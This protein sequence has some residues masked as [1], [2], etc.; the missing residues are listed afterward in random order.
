MDQPH[1]AGV[2]A[3]GP[4]QALAT[5]PAHR[6]AQHRV[7]HPLPPPSSPPWGRRWAS[8]PPP[9]PPPA[10]RQQ[11]PAGRPRRRA[12]RR[13]LLLISAEGRG[14]RWMDRGQV[15]NCTHYLEAGKPG[16]RQATC[17]PNA[18]LPAPPRYSS[19]KKAARSSAM[20]VPLTL[21]AVLLVAA[22]LRL[23]R[24]SFNLQRQ[25]WM[26]ATSGARGGQDRI[27]L[28]GGM[29]VPLSEI[30]PRGCFGAREP[31]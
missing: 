10:G 18:P 21:L 27:I 6:P 1:R 5:L 13:R 8:L 23:I 9:A 11:T 29:R 3:G 31:R 4:L 20:P 16:C 28:C 2:A 7:A 19:F 12:S 15:D 26:G 30:R 25:R 24:S 22:L 17:Q 14:G